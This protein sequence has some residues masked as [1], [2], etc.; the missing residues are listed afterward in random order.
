[1]RIGAT[2]S[3]THYQMQNGKK[4]ERRKPRGKMCTGQVG[5]K[6]EQIA[7]KTNTETRKEKWEG[8]SREKKD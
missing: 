4:G 6:M 5:Q 3:L 1:M 8:A 7:G 2:K